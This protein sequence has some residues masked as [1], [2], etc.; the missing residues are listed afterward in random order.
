[1]PQAVPRI[2]AA[3]LSLAAATVP[4]SGDE[5]PG[6]ADRALGD[7]AWARRAEGHDGPAAAPGPVGEAIAAYE[8]AVAAAPDDAPTRVKLLRA[9]YFLGEYATAD[10]GAKAEVFTRGREVAE[11]GIDRL[12]SGFD[13]DPR[14]RWDDE[15]AHRALA[16]HL[17][18]RPQAVGIYLWAANHWALWGRN[19]GPLAAARQGAAGRIRD[20][21]HVVIALDP[22]YDQAGGWRVLGRLHHEAPRV[23]L[24]TGWIDRREGL[25]ALSRAVELAPDDLLGRL[26]WI[27]SVL[28]HD[29]T[30]RDEAIAS[31]RRL[32]GREPAPEALIE[33]L[34][35]LVDARELLAR[36]EG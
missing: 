24:V 32:A 6:A 31:L 15:A 20:Y 22:T 29:E 30:R 7:A 13:G 19:R 17:A 4:A 3:L 14:P 2:L 18:G 23:P 9:I 5:G 36:V 10:R 26:Y 33:E 8:R 12:A 34:A 11:A 21:A 25:R 28:E 35:I 1:M 16:A 27:E